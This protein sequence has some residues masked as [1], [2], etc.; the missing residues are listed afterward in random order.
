VH[1]FIKG[2]LLVAAVSGAAFCAAQAGEKN[3]GEKDAGAKGAACQSS[4]KL[5]KGVVHLTDDDVR[6]RTADGKVVFV[7]PLAGPGDKLVVKTGMI[8]PDLI[9]ITHPHGDHFQ[10]AVLQQYI[11]A[12]PAVVLAGPADV[13]KLAAEKGIAQMRVVK[14]GEHLSLAGVEVDA[15]PA[16][17]ANADHHP[18]KN[19]WVGYVLQLNGA[20][21]YVTGD[22]QPLAEMASVKADVLFPLLFGCGGNT[23]QAVEMAKLSGARVVVP[24]HHSNQTK[25]IETYMSRLPESVA[26]GYFA[27][28][29]FV[30]GPQTKA[31]AAAAVAGAK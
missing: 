15:V 12:N 23:D 6:F 30:S 28:A 26:C 10:P 20:R 16:Y 19:Q 31:V 14:A 11:A 25:T 24:V 29:E 27:G 3:A 1:P 5:L 17:F 21:Y 2:S 13:A 22:T 9:L 18:Q 8:R 7:D 4:C